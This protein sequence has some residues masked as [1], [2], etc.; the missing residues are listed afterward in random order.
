M[1]THQ[2]ALL[3]TPP[4]SSTRSWDQAAF[5]EAMNNFTAQ[6][7]LGTDWIFDSGTS[8]HMSASRSMMSLCTPSSSFSI[9]LGDGSS[10]PIHCVGHDHIPS[11]NKLLLL[12]DVLVAPALTKKLISIRQFT[13]DNLVFIEFDPFGLS[14]NDYQTKEDFAHFNSS[15]ELYSLHGAPTAAPPMTLVTSIDLWC[16]HLSHPHTATLS[17]LLSDFSIPCN[18]DSHNSSVCESC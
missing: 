6:G 16:Q 14:V 5:I 3:P 15:G 12:C 8:S 9:T 7:N 17:S 13:C 2:P 10:I 11:P 18:R 4:S 1:P